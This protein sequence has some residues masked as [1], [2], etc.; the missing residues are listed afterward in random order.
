MF[1]TL[2][3]TWTVVD[4]ET[5]TPAEIPA[6]RHEITQAANPLDPLDEPWYVLKGTKIGGAQS[7]WHN[8]VG[9]GWREDEVIIEGEAP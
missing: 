4:G 6:G 8:F 9:A 7:Y 2:K 5:N 1:L 3:R